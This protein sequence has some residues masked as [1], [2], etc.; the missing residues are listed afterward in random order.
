M[1]DL[2][3]EVVVPEDFKAMLLKIVQEIIEAFFHV[4]GL[5]FLPFQLLLARLKERV[6]ISILEVFELLYQFFT[7]HILI[8]LFDLIMEVAI[9]IVHLHIFLL[10]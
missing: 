3:F 8:G 1:V 4:D 10:S 5:D 7:G 9:F 6:H 2:I